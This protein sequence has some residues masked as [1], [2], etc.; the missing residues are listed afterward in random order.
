MTLKLIFR[1]VRIFGQ[2]DIFGQKDIFGTA[3]QKLHVGRPTTTYSSARPHELKLITW[4]KP[5]KCKTCEKTFRLFDYL[6]TN[7]RVHTGKKPYKCK[8]CDHSFKLLGHLKHIR[9]HMI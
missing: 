3:G 1:L 9:V 6:E 4:S 5:Y 2:E 8:T 7:E